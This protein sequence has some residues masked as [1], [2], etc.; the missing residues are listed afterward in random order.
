MTQLVPGTISSG[1]ILKGE[2]GRTTISL[3]L[4][5]Q[6]VKTLAAGTDTFAVVDRSAKENFHLKGPGVDRKTNLKKA[7][8]FTWTVVLKKGTYRFFSDANP[9]LKGSFKVG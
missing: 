4:D 6:P 9:K 8:K 5:R 1:V 2:V 7:G 3:K